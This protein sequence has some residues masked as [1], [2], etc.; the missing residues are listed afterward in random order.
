[1]MAGHEQLQLVEESA[2]R[3]QRGEGVG[4]RRFIPVLINKFNVTFL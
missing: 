3:Y 4:S 1:M 2:N